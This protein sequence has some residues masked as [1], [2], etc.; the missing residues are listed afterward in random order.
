MLLT[1][2]DYG[3]QYVSY[4]SFKLDYN[5]FNLMVLPHLELEEYIVVNQGVEV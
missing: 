3:W 5:D 2:K 4:I 1:L